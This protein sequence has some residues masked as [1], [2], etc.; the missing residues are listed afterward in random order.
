MHWSIYL[1]ILFILAEFSGILTIIITTIEKTFAKED[2][3]VNQTVTT[4]DVSTTPITQRISKILNQ[5]FSADI[6]NG[7]TKTL[8]QQIAMVI[9]SD[10]R[11]INPT[12]GKIIFRG[13]TEAYICIDT[14]QIN[15]EDSLLFLT[16]DRFHQLLGDDQNHNRDIS[17]VDFE[18]YNCKKFTGLDSETAYMIDWGNDNLQVKNQGV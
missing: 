7:P 18:T 11:S 17:F 1:S 4:S 16:P 12:T 2:P 3:E 13:S 14:D 15:D 10:F 9:R 8:E 6:N 5:T